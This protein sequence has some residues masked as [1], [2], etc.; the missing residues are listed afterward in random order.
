MAQKPTPV[1]KEP[2]K[3]EWVPGK[4]RADAER[5]V[6]NLK[7]RRVEEGDELSE[8]EKFLR[9]SDTE[10]RKSLRTNDD[11]AAYQNFLKS[12]GSLGRQSFS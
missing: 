5:A 6:D 7:E 8:E 9:M 2:E 10:R 1:I 11:D 3:S 4:G 12:T